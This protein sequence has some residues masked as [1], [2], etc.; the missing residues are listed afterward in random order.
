MPSCSSRP[1]ETSLFH[2]ND[3]HTFDPIRS[4][5]KSHGLVSCFRPN[6]FEDYA[7]SLKTIGAVQELGIIMQVAA[8][9]QYEDL[10][11]AIQAMDDAEHGEAHWL[12]LRQELRGIQ[13]EQLQGTPPPRLTLL[14]CLLCS[15]LSRMGLVVTRIVARRLTRSQ[16][17]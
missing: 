17:L 15:L 14:F 1:K 7:W 9:N 16:G 5:Q 12:H 3:L 11:Q 2:R 6:G 4:D 8:T 13:E 10:N